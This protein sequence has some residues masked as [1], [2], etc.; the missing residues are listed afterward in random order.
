MHICMHI[1]MCICTYTHMHIYHLLAGTQS[2]TR[3]KGLVFRS[4]C[5]TTSTHCPFCCRNR[6][7][8][9][10]VCI[11]PWSVRRNEGRQHT[12]FPHIIRTPSVHTQKVF[13]WA[14]DS[15][16]KVLS[17]AMC[18]ASHSIRAICPQQ[19][20]TATNRHCNK[21]VLQK[22]G[23]ALRVDRPFC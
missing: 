19:I 17:W 13:F 10:C 23:T 12:F 3:Q 15:V 4:T 9:I 22:I 11:S 20:G 5:N 18:W 1:C 7:L 8:H 21:S 14:V 2:S 16:C 6:A